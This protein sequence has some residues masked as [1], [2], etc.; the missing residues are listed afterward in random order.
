MF[1]DKRRVFLGL[2]AAVTIALPSAA[3]DEPVPA[4]VAEAV[5]LGGQ[6][7][8]TSALSALRT[9]E[10]QLAKATHDKGGHRVKALA[11]VRAAIAQVKQGIAHDAKH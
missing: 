9:A 11:H 7:H 2:L 10:A 4:A 6:P 5:P 3:S 1:L 8:M